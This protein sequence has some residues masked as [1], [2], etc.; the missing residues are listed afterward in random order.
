MELPSHEAGRL[1]LSGVRASPESSSGRDMCEG[2][3]DVLVEV[4]AEQPDFRVGRLEV[5][6]GPETQRGGAGGTGHSQDTDRSTDGCVCEQRRTQAGGL[7]GQGTTRASE[8]TRKGWPTRQEQRGE[9]RVRKGCAAV[10]TTVRG[11]AG[12]SGD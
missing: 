1:W 9:G 10:C 4:L 8:V 12:G 5:N 6:S 11:A 3:S 7:R 2:L